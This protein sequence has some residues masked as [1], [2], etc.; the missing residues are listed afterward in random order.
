MKNRKNPLIVQDNCHGKLFFRWLFIILYIFNFMIL[1]LG[2]SH[3]KLNINILS[4]DYIQRI[5]PNI[6]TLI[7]F[8]LFIFGRLLKKSARKSMRVM[9]HICSYDE[10]YSM[11]GNETFKEIKNLGYDKLYESELWLK[12]DGVFV[13][14][15][16]IVGAYYINKM[17]GNKI[18][19]IVLITGYKCFYD[20][21]I[22]AEVGAHTFGTF[23]EM[24]PNSDFT[25]IYEWNMNQSRIRKILKERCEKYISEGHTVKELVNNYAD[26]T[27]GI[28][29]DAS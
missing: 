21:G 10:V 4:S 12:I 11:L 13:P 24:L 22:D 14:K 20:M 7:L 3:D 8:S 27:K 1:V 28:W 19:C 29:D 25:H 9:K 5:M 18:M 23:N 6:V 26:F 2:I 15:N 16:F 17:R